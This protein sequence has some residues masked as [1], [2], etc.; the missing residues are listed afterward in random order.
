MTIEQK[1]RV[2]VNLIPALIA[3]ML[4]MLMPRLERAFFPVVR[5]F[6]ITAL[7]VYG[8][9]VVM[10]GYMRKVR[11]CKFVGVQA[12][13]VDSAGRE[14]DVPLIFLDAAD[15]N[16][17]RKPGSQNW[18]PWKVTVKVADADSIKL[19]STHRCHWVY[20]V[21]TSLANIPLRGL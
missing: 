5:D 15:N 17:T 19:V 3:A 11:D 12:L 8:D 13:G 18:G 2:F 20:A 6:G 1:T 14:S 4:M 7:N 10:S 16:A 9:T 21:D